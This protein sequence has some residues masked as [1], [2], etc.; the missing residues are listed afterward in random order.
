VRGDRYDDVNSTQC[1]FPARTRWLKSNFPEI[2]ECK[3]LNRQ[4]QELGFKSIYIIFVSS[5][6]KL[7]SLLLWD[8]PFLRFDRGGGITPL[9]SSIIGSLKLNFR[10]RILIG[11]LTG[12]YLRL[13]GLTIGTSFGG[14]FTWER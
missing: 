7:S 14:N 8:T 6:L 12:Y 4:L 3:Y 2:R 10:G 11:F 5:Y 9:N 13:T 1:R